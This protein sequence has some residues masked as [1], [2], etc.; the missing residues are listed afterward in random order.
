MKVIMSISDR[1]VVLSYGEKI[2]EGTPQEI[3]SNPEVIEAYLGE[4]AMLEVRGIDVFYGDVQVIWDLSFEVGTGGDRRPDRRQRRGQVDDPEDRLRAPEAPPRRDSIPRRV[5]TARGGL[6]PRSSIGIAL[7]EA[8]RLFVEMT[9]EENLDMGSLRGEAKKKR[10]QTKE[11]VFAIFPRLKERR[12]QLAGT[13]SG[14]RAADGRRRSRAD[15]PAEADDVRRAVARPRADPGPG[16]L[17]RRAPN[18]R[19]GDDGP[20]RR[21]ERQA[22]RSPS[23]TAPT[24]SRP[25]RSRCRA[26]GRTC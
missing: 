16:D 7:P 21:A 10:E 22:R 17:R 5:A 24:C 13:L 15:E 23:P 4:A 12:R 25:A 8:R 1:I 3:G 2:A 18:P 9:V 14:G 26:P 20:H 19:R 6:G 11:Q